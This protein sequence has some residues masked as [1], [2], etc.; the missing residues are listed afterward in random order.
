MLAGPFATQ[1]LGDL[2][3]DIIKVEPPDGDSTRAIPPRRNGESHYF[4]GVN[5]NKR[6]IV[7]DLKKDRGVGLIKQFAAHVDVL[8]E[9]YRPGVMD[10]LGLGYEPLSEVNPKLIY[11]A[12]SGFGQYGPMRDKPSF[13]IVTQA[14]TGAMSLNGERES[15]P[16]KL[17]LPMG[18]LVGGLFGPVSVLA[19]LLERNRTER[20]R[21][22]DVSLYDGLLGML[23]YFAQ[24]FLFEGKEPKPVG[25]GHPS[26]AP[27]GAYETSDGQI[28]IACLTEGFWKRLVQALDASVLLDDPRFASMESRRE[29][30]EALDGIL[31][32]T[33]R[34][35]TTR[36]M[37]K[38]LDEFDI[39]N[40]PIL[41][42]G[43]ALSSSHSSAREMLTT[44][45]HEVLG[46]IP[47]VGRSVKFP[48]NQQSRLRAPPALGQHTDEILS[49]VLGLRTS[50]IDKLRAA[51]VVT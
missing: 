20:G 11:C 10:S 38:L 5:R 44:A 16:V 21:M 6:S 39:P 25:S 34:Q 43:E 17:G 37:S 18:D 2:G 12:M 27:Y 40:A 47:L 50:E 4:I 19:A 49:E 28:V 36:E 48:G 32:S 45:H 13:D 22:I 24:L 29:N 23:G 1:V 9:N 42:V 8:I 31:A 51:G 3:A 41:G 7:V 33:T 15:T 30:R 26:I 46:H 35:R 14:L